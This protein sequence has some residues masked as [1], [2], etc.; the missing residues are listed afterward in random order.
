M[1][2]FLIVGSRDIL[3]LHRIIAFNMVETSPGIGSSTVEYHHYIY[4][5][6]SGLFAWF[7]PP[8]GDRRS[9]Q[10]GRDMSGL[11]HHSVSTLVGRR[12]TTYVQVMRLLQ[13][14]TCELQSIDYQKHHLR[15]KRCSFLEST[16]QAK[17]LLYR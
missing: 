3:L 11:Q 2:L 16:D 5:S 15:I 17:R 6:I 14:D 10:Q 4:P 13:D 9:I 8:D 12:K 7:S 1:I